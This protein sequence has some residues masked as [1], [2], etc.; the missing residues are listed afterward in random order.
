MANASIEVSGPDAER[1]AGCGRDA[2]ALEIEF[3]RRATPEN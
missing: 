1:L 3:K 2:N